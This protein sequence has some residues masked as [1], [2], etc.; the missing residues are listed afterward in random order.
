MNVHVS[1]KLLK[2]SDLEHEIN[3]QIHKLEKR[4]QVFRP[5]LI[6]LHAIIEEKPARAGIE[7]R[8]DLRLPSGDIAARELASSAEAAIKGAFEDLLERLGKHK[9]K[10]RAQHKWPNRRRVARTRPV[11]E[12]PFEETVAAVQIPQASEEDISSYLNA[13]L[14]R[15]RRFVEREITY[16]ENNDELTPGQ[17]GTDEVIDEAIANAL[18]H[19]EKPE[20]L[21]LEPWLYRLALRAISDLGRRSR[22]DESSLSLDQPARVYDMSATIHD[23]LRTEYHQP[24]EVTSRES[25]IA[26]RGLSSPEDTA[27]QSEVITL[28]ERALHGTKPE[29]REAFLLFTIEGFTVDEIVAISSRPVDAVRNSINSAREYLRRNLPVP[30]HLKDKLLEHSKAV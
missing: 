27:A 22:E 11:P 10:L 7:A 29:D 30:S 26:N 5:D 21:S 9:D 8:L 24:D 1:Y 12:T 3:Q 23:E 17:L 13:N 15:L 2:T 6:H 18:D 19:H 14:P 16:R 25:L 28:I 20:K 4:L